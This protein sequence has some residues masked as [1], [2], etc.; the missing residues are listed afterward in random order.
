MGLFGKVVNGIFGKNNNDSKKSNF[1]KQLEIDGTE[2]TG[3]RVAKIINKHIASENMAMQFILEELDAASQG[4][5]H[6]KEFVNNSGISSLMYKGAMN[7]STWKGNENELEQCQLLFRT[8]LIDIGDRELMTE[9]CTSAVD[10]IMRIWSL[11]K[12]S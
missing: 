7:K 6:S 1:E 9:V 2:Y 12:Y 10:E 3:K 4:N 11:G 8:I 5:R